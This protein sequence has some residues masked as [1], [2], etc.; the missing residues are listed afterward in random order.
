QAVSFSTDDL[1]L[2]DRSEEVDI[3]TRAPG[4][5]P[6]RAVIWVVVDAGDVFIRSVRGERGRWYRDAVANPAVAL[7]VGRRRLTATAIAASDPD[8]VERVSAALRRKYA[9]D[10][11]LATML[12]EHTLPTTLRLEPA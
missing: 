11:A 4:G 1:A 7:L 10:P 12:R 8:S 6:H 5:D 9:A 2:L 3:E